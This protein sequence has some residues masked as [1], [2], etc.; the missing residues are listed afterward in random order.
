MKKNMPTVAAIIPARGGSKGLPGKNIKNF[1]GKPLLAWSI[2]AALKSRYLDEVMVT[3]EDKKIAAVARH[4]G[5]IIID[6]PKGLATDTAPV[7]EAMKHALT[8]LSKSQRRPD[9]VMILQPTS[10][11]RTTATLDRAIEVFFKNFGRYDSL[12]PLF[13]VE[14]KLGVIKNNTYSPGYKLGTRRQDM[15]QL[16]RECG[17]I[18][19][20]KTN[21]ILANRGF[22]KKVYPFIV[23]R[24]AEAIDIDTVEDFTLAERFLSE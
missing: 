12:V 3:T 21:L 4:Y 8:E 15:L 13:P 7:M 1:G 2:E 5:A 14:G 11:L 6:R 19:A 24:F 10:P 17:T 9:I 22:G 20:L 18:F 23:D 16:Y